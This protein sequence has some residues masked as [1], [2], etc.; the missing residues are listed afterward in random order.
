MH[1]T[2]TLLVDAENLFKR[3]APKTNQY[4]TNSNGEFY[5]A[6]Y[7]FMTS[8]RK[9][10]KDLTPNKVILFWDGENGGKGRYLI[11][12]EYKANRES[13]SWYNKIQ[14]TEKEVK[15]LNKSKDSEL[16]NRTQIKRYCEELYIR[17]IDVPLI[18]ADDLIAKYVML[19]QGTEEM[20]ICS[21]DRDYLQLL[22]F[23]IT[24]HASNRN[25]PL[26]KFNSELFLPYHYKNALVMKVICGDNS[27]NIQG[28]KGVGEKTL[29]EHFPELKDK[30]VMVRDILIKA[31]VINEERVSQKKTPLKALENLLSSV[32]RLKT[33]YRLMNLSEPFLNETAL[34]ELEY[35]DYPLSDKSNDGTER[36]SKALLKMMMDDGFLNMY[37]RY[38]NFTEY[39]TPFFIVI[40]R[41]KEIL[42]KYLSEQAGQDQ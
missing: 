10:I 26:T 41:E 18:E 37:S 7:G 25:F 24:I 29:L 39:V 13:K 15:H 16:W 36:G 8:L 4:I 5:G 19:H 9:M 34:T 17:Q 32:E 22:D 30:Q 31:K 1:N 21:N 2:K 14:L 20:I 35:L 42:K 6:L 12:P 3:S 11:D 27:D 28:V 40:A 38:G 23:G 33:N